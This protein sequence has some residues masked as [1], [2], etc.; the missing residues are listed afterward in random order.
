MPS[1]R[2][3][4]R[5]YDVFCQHRIESWDCLQ[6]GLMNGLYDVSDS[7]EVTF[8][9]PT[10]RF[11]ES[12][13]LIDIPAMSGKQGPRSSAS[14]AFCGLWILEFSREV[15]TRTGWNVQNELFAH[16]HVAALAAASTVATFAS[17]D[18]ASCSTTS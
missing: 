10:A 2:R 3:E 9:V 11:F 5:V 16:H 18:R 13:S 8:K 15:K 7:A 4:P 17:P 12:F 1:V 6:N 14:L